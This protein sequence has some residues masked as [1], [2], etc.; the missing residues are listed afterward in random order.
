[1][2][3]LRSAV[4]TFLTPQGL[5]AIAC[6]TLGL[7]AIAASQTADAAI[8][9]RQSASASVSTKIKQNTKR[10]VTEDLANEQD[11]ITLRIGETTVILGDTSKPVE[12]RLKAVEQALIHM[13]RIQGVLPDKSQHACELKVLTE[14]FTAE[15]STKSLAEKRT[16]EL[17]QEKFSELVCSNNSI[18]CHG[19]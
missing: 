16:I 13:Y 18:D 19:L 3:T 10:A 11:P 17:C 14:K 15:G 5:R 2:K 7:L 4:L 1:M 9:K 12:A 8:P 6:L